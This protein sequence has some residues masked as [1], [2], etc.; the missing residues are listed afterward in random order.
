VLLGQRLA[1]VLIFVY[2]IWTNRV[3]ALETTAIIIKFIGTYSPPRLSQYQGES[4]IAR[5]CSAPKSY[6]L[7]HFTC[8]SN[9]KE[10]YLDVNFKA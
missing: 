6:A 1:Y 3:R 9:G 10:G 7:V 2:N 5:F 8:A 4:C